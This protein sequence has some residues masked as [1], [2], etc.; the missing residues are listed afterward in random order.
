[1]DDNE[2]KTLLQ[3]FKAAQTKPVDSMVTVKLSVK[4]EAAQEWDKKSNDGKTIWTYSAAD[5]VNSFNGRFKFWSSRRLEVGKV[6][7]VLVTL[8]GFKAR[9]N[10]GGK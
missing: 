1:M 5:P 8:T 6:Q 9:E 10:I 4:I 2:A 3:G 7:D